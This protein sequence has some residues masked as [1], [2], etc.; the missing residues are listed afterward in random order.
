MNDPQGRPAAALRG[1]PWVHPLVLAMGLSIV[2]FVTYRPVLHG[3]FIVDDSYLVM[4]NAAIRDLANVPGFFVHTPPGPIVRNF[5]RP[6]MLASFAL[7]YALFGASPAGYH[8]TNVVL[9]ALCVVFV[10]LL[11][12]HLGASPIAAFCGA[13]LFAVHPLQSEAVDVVNYRSATLCALFFFAGLYAYLRMRDEPLTWARA[14]L[15]AV[16]Y[17]ASLAAKETGITLPIVMLACDFLW[18]RARPA[19][20]PYAALM[21][22]GLLYLGLRSALCEPGTFVHFAGTPWTELVMTMTVVEAHALSLVVFPRGLAGV[23][24][25]CFLPNVTS[26]LDPRFLLAAAVLM[27]LVVLAYR[28]RRN[29]PWLS[30]SA[31]IYVVTLAP[32]CQLLGRLPV[33][34]GERFLYLPLLGMALAVAFAIDRAPRLD[35]QRVLVG[36]ALTGAMLFAAQSQLRTH[37]FLD[38]ESFWRAAVLSEPDSLQPQLGLAMTLRRA[39]RCKEALPYFELAMRRADAAQLRGRSIF[40]EAISCYSLTGQRALARA[41]VATWL[42]R[43]PDD[44]G[45]AG[46]QRALASGP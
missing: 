5:Y 42:A 8:A 6:V 16:L 9:H 46:M 28:A 36:A 29:R 40:G 27:A 33:V 1:A 3:G 41:V 15:L 31:A 26:T 11:L 25:T 4:N 7:D 35:V 37:D 44:V 19:L 24:D 39:G 23:Y 20:L 38:E 30:L 14:L 10:L 2:C 12:L 22:V 43:H 13:L 32:T 34:F 18:F 21:A 17:F 45:F